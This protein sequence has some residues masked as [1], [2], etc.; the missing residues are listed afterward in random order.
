MDA[1]AVEPEMAK[2]APVITLV[3]AART[4][5]TPVDKIKT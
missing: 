5:A 3:I 2:P 1:A 4:P